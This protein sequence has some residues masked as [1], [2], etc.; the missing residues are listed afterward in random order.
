MKIQKI[1]YLERNFKKEVA[2]QK[3]WIIVAQKQEIADQRQDI[4]AHLVVHREGNLMTRHSSPISSPE[5]RHQ[6]NIRKN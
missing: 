3:D 1:I 5:K 4:V 6:T 2:A